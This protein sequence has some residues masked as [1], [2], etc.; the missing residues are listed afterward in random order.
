MSGI[1]SFEVLLVLLIATCVVGPQ[2]IRPILKKTA[3]F[4]KAVKK[5]FRDIKQESEVLSEVSA[6]D[7]E[8]REIQK[9]FKS[10]EL[11][12]IAK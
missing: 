6:I 8:I 1:G 10:D 7:E 3:V 9:E 5:T 2:N 12:K 11:E 4:I